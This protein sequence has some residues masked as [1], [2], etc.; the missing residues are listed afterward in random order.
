MTAITDDILA[1]DIPPV[2]TTRTPTLGNHLRAERLLRG[3]TLERASDL[4]GI[5]L[6]FLSDMERD[7]T[8]P[9]LDTLK[10]LARIYG[11]STGALLGDAT[12]VVVTTGVSTNPQPVP[13]P[14]TPEQR[15]ALAILG[16]YIKT[17][18]N[19]GDHA[20]ADL[21]QQVCMVIEDGQAAD[22]AA[23]V[24]AWREGKG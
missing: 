13:R 9:S 3:W 4:A 14:L 8:Q 10:A 11:T 2:A 1:G 5:S 15:G 23:L 24:R 21:L 7:R 12:V 20:T 6:S 17:M 18:R 22:A 19:N 16:S